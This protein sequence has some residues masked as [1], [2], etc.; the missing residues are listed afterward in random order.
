[1]NGM[2]HDRYLSELGIGYARTWV[3]NPLNCKLYMSGHNGNLSLEAGLGFSAACPRDI[4][5]PLCCGWMNGK[6]DISLPGR[7]TAFSFLLE[8]CDIDRFDGSSNDLRILAERGVSGIATILEFIQLCKKT[9]DCLVVSRG[10]NT[11][12]PV[13]FL[14]SLSRA[15]G[16]GG[17]VEKS[18]GQL[19]R[20]INRLTIYGRVLC[21]LGFMLSAA[22]FISPATWTRISAYVARNIAS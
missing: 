2:Q 14:L 19:S 5:N 1:M 3:S 16:D 22:N 17:L 8:E 12:H 21:E 11:A 13:R 9:T 6:S 20:D 7:C 10:R 4:L 15:N 18:C